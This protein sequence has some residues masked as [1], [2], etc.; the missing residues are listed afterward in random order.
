MALSK[1]QVNIVRNYIKESKIETKFILNDFLDHICC[2]IE[3]KMNDNTSFEDSLNYAINKISILEIKKTEL[4]TLKTLNM[5]TYFS[6]RTSLLAT[7]PFI[8]FTISWVFTNPTIKIPLFI[9][10]LLFFSS[11]ISMFVLFGIG[12]IKNFPRWSLPSIGFCLLISLFL[13][14]V[15]IPKVSSELLG[16]WAWL[17]FAITLLICVVIKP[18]IEPLK[19]IKN[20]IVDSPS[21]ILF[22]LYGISPFI[23]FLLTDEISSPLLTPIIIIT[24]LFLIVGLFLYLKSKEKHIRV[25]S[26]TLS[27]VLAISTVM[28]FCNYYWQ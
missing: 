12:W 17:P 5:E 3:D 23:A 16:I 2:L 27:F 9:E 15:K 22:S 28:I 19:S 13:M 8:L 14:N 7:I 10:S 11:I 21:L 6:K 20:K 26:I 4:L 24:M 1:E 18:S 25:V